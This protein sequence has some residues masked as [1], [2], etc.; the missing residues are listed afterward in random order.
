MW[1]ACFDQGQRHPGASEGPEV[2]RASGVLQR[3]TELGVRLVDH[4]DLRHDR[5][6]DDTLDNR[7]MATARFSKATYDKVREILGLE[8]DKDNAVTWCGWT[9]T[10]TSTL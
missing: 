9:P 1:G 8:E 7:Q 5:A 4:G 2:I 10:K 6:E 3:L